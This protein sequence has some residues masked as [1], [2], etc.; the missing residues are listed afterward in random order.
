MSLIGKTALTIYRKLPSSGYL[1]DDGNWIDNTADEVVPIVCSLQPFRNG[2]Q[3]LDLPD[4]IRSEDAYF[5]YTKTEILSADDRQPTQKADETEIKGVRYEC[6]RVEDWTHYGLS[7]DHYKCV[8]IKK[9]KL[10]G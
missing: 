5:I 10:G 2:D 9:D 4:G 3:Q 1:D 8:F 6:F 7:T